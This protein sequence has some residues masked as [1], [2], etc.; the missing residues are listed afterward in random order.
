MQNKPI[1]VYHYDNTPAPKIEIGKPVY[2]FPAE[3]EEVNYD[4]VPK[5][6]RKYGLTKTSNVISYDVQSGTFETWDAIYVL[7]EKA[8]AQ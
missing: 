6:Q 5:I 7:Q 8:Q 3:L 1:I 2:L 4:G